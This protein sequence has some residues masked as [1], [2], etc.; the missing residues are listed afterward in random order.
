MTT[1][2]RPSGAYT[3][4]AGLA[5]RSKYQ[6]DALAVPKVAISSAKMDGDINYLVDA[7]NVL[8]A[9]KGSRASVDERMSVVLNAD[10]TLKASVTASLDDWISLAAGTLT[11]VDD[12]TLTIGGG[13]FTGTLAVNRRIK[14]S[15]SPA[16]VG[17]VASV[18]H[19]GGIT[20]VVFKNLVSLAGAPSVLGTSLTSVAY[21]PMTPSVAGNTPRVSEAMTIAGYDFKVSGS[22]LAV[23]PAGGSGGAL[24]TPAGL[25]GVAAGAVDM[26]ALTSAVLE[27]MT[28]TGTVVPFAGAAAPTGWLLCAGQAVSRTT[29]AALFAVLGTTY[30][31]GDGST[32]FA[33]PD[34]RGRA[35]FGVD[36]MGGMAAARVTAGVS[37][38]AGNT[39]GAAGG[40][41][42]LQAHTHT[43]TDPG[44]IHSISTNTNGGTAMSWGTSGGPDIQTVSTQSAVTGITLENSGAGDAQNMPPAM[45]LSYMIK[46]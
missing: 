13:D 32:T 22:D 46:A 10:G 4:E 33:V 20:T 38:L 6:D 41:E 17:D 30:G 15:G 43:V 19:A 14:I 40:H 9:A 16:V 3:G 42:A 37:G 5:N 34:L 21:G 2:E 26:A 35:V 23:V 25:S 11:R 36:T 8:N 12:V 44:H 31:A 27:K 7:L 29:Y 18:A 24:I 1:F 45:M 39:L 28:P